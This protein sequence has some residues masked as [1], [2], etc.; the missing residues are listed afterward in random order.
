MMRRGLFLVVAALTFVSQVAVASHIPA[1]DDEPVSRCQEGSRH[2]CAEVA[3]DAAGPCVLCQA[4][5][6]GLGFSL[7]PLSEAFTFAEALPVIGEAGPRS[8][9]KFSP[10]A[11]RG[12]PIV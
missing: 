3:D 2:F 1:L 6:G 8:A 9:L 5:V 4:S 12:P 7:A 10:A 11:P